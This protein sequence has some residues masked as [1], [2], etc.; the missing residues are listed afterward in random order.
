MIQ[1]GNYTPIRKKLLALTIYSACF[2]RKGDRERELGFKVLKGCL[3]PAGAQRGQG[4]FCN[5]G[6]HWAFP[7]LC[8]CV[9]VCVCV[10]M[11]SPLLAHTCLVLRDMIDQHASSSPGP[12]QHKLLTCDLTK[13]PH[14]A[15]ESDRLE[16]NV[17]SRHLDKSNYP[18]DTEGCQCC[19]DIFR[20]LSDI[21]PGRG[22][23]L[24]PQ[25]SC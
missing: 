17:N 12:G 10:C 25:K 14:R 13:F 15:H 20:R 18:K 3:Q 4:C 21:L 11:L 22:W 1:H 8:V 2:K 7:D 5:N 24:G 9:C 6:S 19:Q 16:T 23:L